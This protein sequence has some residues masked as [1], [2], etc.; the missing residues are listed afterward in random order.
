MRKPPPTLRPAEE[1]A[2]D[3]EPV[4][5]QAAAEDTP[6][7]D[8]TADADDQPAAEESSSDDEAADEP[9]GQRGR[10]ACLNGQDP[11]P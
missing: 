9:V 10:R 5:G 7:V 8:D 3:V 4:E 6:G 1:G 11:N 2:D